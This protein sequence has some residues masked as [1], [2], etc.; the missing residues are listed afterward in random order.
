MADNIDKKMEKME[1]SSYAI[2]EKELEELKE[3]N[4]SYANKK[5][6]VMIDDY[7]DELTK[8]YYD[9]LNKINREYN[10]SI[11]DYE[12]NQK[13]KINM[14]KEKLL[15]NIYLKIDSEI[16]SFVNSP[17]YKDYLFKNVSFTLNKFSNKEKCVIYLTENDYY[18]F[19]KEIEEKFNS[20]IEKI[21][22]ENIGGCIIV[23]EIEKISI[24][25]TIKTNIE[26]KNRGGKFA[27]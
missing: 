14:F 12:M 2:A 5:I 16:K 13:V 1:K 15:N 21:N 19:G 18:N 6:S 20:K 7:K 22:N 24:D 25:N 23:N 8:K 3:E 11:F 10:K 17:E 27:E 9:E 4:D 26:L